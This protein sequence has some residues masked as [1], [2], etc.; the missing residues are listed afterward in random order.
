MFFLKT[1]FCSVVPCLCVS[2]LC[3]DEGCLTRWNFGQLRRG[4]V[5]FNS[6]LDGI[7]EFRVVMFWNACGLQRGESGKNKGS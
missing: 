6:R 5:N 4:H 3:R 2:G 1:F 7:V